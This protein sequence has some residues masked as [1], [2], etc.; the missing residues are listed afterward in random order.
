MSQG[1]G[2]IHDRTNPQTVF[3]LSFTRMRLHN[4]RI[5]ALDCKS[6][7][8]TNR[9][10][11]IAV[12]GFESLSSHKQAYNYNGRSSKRLGNR[13]DTPVIRVRISAS[14]QRR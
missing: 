10:I 7:L 11:G 6:N 12:G 5:T 8:F 2:S 4:E 3:T 1:I 14:Q 9:R 13:S